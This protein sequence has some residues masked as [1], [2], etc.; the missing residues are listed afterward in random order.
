M[1]QH[2]NADPQPSFPDVGRS[3]R[4][5]GVREISKGDAGG[6]RARPLLSRARHAVSAVMGAGGR[7]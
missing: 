3:E 1:R 5:C 6:R 7:P 2:L 4:K